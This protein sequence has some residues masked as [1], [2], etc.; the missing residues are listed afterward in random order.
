[1]HGPITMSLCRAATAPRLWAGVDRWRHEARRA[2][3]LALIGPQVLLMA[4]A[5]FLVLVRARHQPVDRIA[6]SLLEAVLP[7]GAAIAIAG[8]VGSDPALEVQLSLPASYRGSLARRFAV[9]L[10]ICA[11]T[12]WL[13][14]IV[15]GGVNAWHAPTGALAA[16]LVW[17]IPLSVLCAVA[18]AVATATGNG[19]IAAGVVA[20]LWVAEEYFKD[21]L[22]TPR[23]AQPLYLFATARAD[24][25]PYLIHGELTHAWF[26]NRAV[27]AAVACAAIAFGWMALRSPHRL[28]T[29]GEKS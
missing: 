18:G 29:K 6:G 2:G 27:L 3:L 8:L 21:A 7:L 17:L 15:F 20:G 9:A 26:V 14:T 19:R 4:G 11:A 23:W 13:G 25:P 5:G 10:G 24:N 22:I 16:Q 12:A 28:L 1:M